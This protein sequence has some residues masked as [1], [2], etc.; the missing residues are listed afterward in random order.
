MIHPI[1]ALRSH[2]QDLRADE[3]HRQV[4]KHCK[5]CLRAVASSVAEIIL[6]HHRIQCYLRRHILLSAF[7]GG[8]HPRGVWSLESI[9]VPSEF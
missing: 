8:S 5:S 6:M 7:G 3:A 4:K 1:R 9:G 2:R